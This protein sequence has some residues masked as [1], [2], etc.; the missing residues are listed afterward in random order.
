VRHPRRGSFWSA[1]RW[2]V[3][4]LAVVVAGILLAFVLDRTSAREFA[5]VIGAPLITILLPIGA[6][7]LL[8]ALVVYLIRRARSG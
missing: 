5:L 7:W 6:V 2:P 8:I 1:V 4:L 3:L